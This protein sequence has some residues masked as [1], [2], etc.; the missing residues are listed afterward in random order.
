MIFGRPLA[1]QATVR[2]DGETYLVHMDPPPGPDACLWALHDTWLALFPGALPDEQAAF[3][4]ERLTNPED[5]LSY[6]SL[7]PVAF[8]LARQLYGVP[9]WAAHRITEEAAAAYLAYESWTVQRGFDPAGQ[10]ARRI[11]A[12]IIAWAS[13]SWADEADVKSWQQ[14]T[15]MPPPGVRP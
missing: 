4:D 7:R 12:S 6:A 15:F 14:R 1:L 2:L 9:W 3:W 10:P 13:E 5:S 11:I 8:E